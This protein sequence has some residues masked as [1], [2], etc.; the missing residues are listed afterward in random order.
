VRV[1]EYVVLAGGSLYLPYGEPLPKVDVLVLL[2]WRLYSIGEKCEAQ[3]IR[4]IHHGVRDYGTPRR[5][6]WLALLD[7]IIQELKA[8]EEVA[9]YCGGGHGRTGMLL[10]SLIAVLEP[11]MDPAQ[12]VRE[13]Y[14]FEA[15]ENPRQEAFVRSIR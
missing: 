5:K 2:T 8:G 11:E 6:P 10:G 15:I 14:C 1:G 9:I 13:R 3:G 12:A 4:F 7:R